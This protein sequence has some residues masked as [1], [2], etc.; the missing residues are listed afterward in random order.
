[1]AKEVREVEPEAIWSI[2]QGYAG[3]AARLEAH[4]Q[5]LKS[6]R[7]VT[8]DK[9]LSSR[10]EKGKLGE[11]LDA[12]AADMESSAILRVASEQGVPVVCVRAILDELD[13]ELP[14][15]LETIITPDGAPRVL[16]TLQA[17]ARKPSGLF[18]LL[19]LR[20]RAQ[21]ATK[22]LGAFLPRLLE[23]LEEEGA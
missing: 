16:G 18:K 7:L 2:P 15:D 22:S 17:I 11:A 19:D 21:T 4:G 13:F 12:D 5:R 14:F 3:V 1:M 8:V 6:G 23:A 10:A 9:V 20:S